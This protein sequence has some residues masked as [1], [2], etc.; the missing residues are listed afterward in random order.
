[1]ATFALPGWPWGVRGT[2]KIGRSPFH[3]SCRFTDNKHVLVPTLHFV[4]PPARASRG[5]TAEGSAV[6]VN[7]QPMLP[8]TKMISTHYSRSYVRRGITGRMGFLGLSLL[9]HIGIDCDCFALSPGLAKNPPY[10][11]AHLSS[12]ARMV[13]SRWPVRPLVSDRLAARHPG[14]PAAGRPYDTTSDTDV[15]C[16][17]AIA[18]GRASGS[19][20]TGLASLCASRWSGSFLPY[21]GAAPAV[22]CADSSRIRLA[23]HE[24]RLP[25]LARPASL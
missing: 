23:G 3:C 21:P 1:M 8:R 10:P 12:L 14:R 16:A 9:G 2:K 7:P 6:S 13:L 20:T 11:A 5:S 19:T 4:I 22:P 15:G 24:Y 25:R 18:S 17:A